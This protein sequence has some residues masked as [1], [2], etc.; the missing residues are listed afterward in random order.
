MYFPSITVFLHP[1]QPITLSNHLAE[2]SS[3]LSFKVD[4]FFL[5]IHFKV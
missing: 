4:E 1:H 2:G 5:K 3:L